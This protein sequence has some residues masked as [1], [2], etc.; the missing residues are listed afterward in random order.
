MLDLWEVLS[1]ELGSA[2][3]KQYGKPLGASF[4]HWT[5]ELLE[6]SAEEL[7]A[8]FERFKKSGSTYMSLNV[9]RNHCRPTA[10]DLGVDELDDALLRVCAGQWERLHPCFY[11]VCAK[12]R[13][14]LR[15][16]SYAEARREFVDL[17]RLVLKRV[18]RGE[19]FEPQKA[20]EQA[21]KLRKPTAEA[22]RKG[23]KVLD[24]LLGDLKR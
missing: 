16:Q 2:F 12:H 3:V 11:A 10:E 8:G 20:L 17:Y 13:F 6:F 21:P 4:D 9:F 1:K 5:N 24:E 22:I 18:S 14:K 15:T 23:R 7:Y 19:Q